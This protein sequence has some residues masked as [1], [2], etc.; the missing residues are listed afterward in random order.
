MSISIFVVDDDEHFTETLR[1]SF[2]TKGVDVKSAGTGAQALKLLEENQPSIIL[3]DIQLPDMHGFELCR[4]L[5][6][7]SRLKKVPIILLSAKYTEPADRAE[8][9]LAGADTFISKP[10]K[11][12]VLWEEIKYLLDKKP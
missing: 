2:A 1:D 10:A 8:G 12:E 3:L 4:I 5:K 11:I 7:S 9:M 6:K